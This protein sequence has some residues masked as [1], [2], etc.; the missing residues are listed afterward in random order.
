MGKLNLTTDTGLLQDEVMLQR[1]A[2]YVMY[3]LKRLISDAGEMITIRHEGETAD[4]AF[5]ER[6]AA[7][8]EIIAHLEA[9]YKIFN[10][11]NISFHEYGWLM[12]AECLIDDF[13]EF[14]KARCADG[15]H[16]A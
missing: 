9:A 5:K 7:V 4:A 12:P 15:C 11:K 13:G 8:D 14:L 2:S 3:L 16:R 10:S 6:M 1:K